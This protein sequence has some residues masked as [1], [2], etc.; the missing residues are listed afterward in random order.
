MQPRQRYQKKK[1]KE[2]SSNGRLN[3]AAADPA[4]V[5][6][7]GAPNDLLVRLEDAIYDA[8]G[9]LFE[10]VLNDF[11][12]GMRKLK[13]SGQMKENIRKMDGVKE[14]VWTRI[15]SQAYDRMVSPRVSDLRVYK[16]FS[17]EV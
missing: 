13:Q 15:T 14:A 1:R 12:E 17:D 5:P 7:E 4:L 3:A 9:D 11:N 8:D 16:P 2:A 10:K 6:L